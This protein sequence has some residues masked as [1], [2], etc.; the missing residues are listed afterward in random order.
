MK[1]VIWRFIKQQKAFAP[2]KC[3][4]RQVFPP[5]GMT[6]SYVV[7]ENANVLRSHEVTCDKVLHLTGTTSVRGGSRVG[8]RGLQPGQILH[9]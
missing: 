9:I 4:C 8:L 2:P 3:L 1:L 7:G 6:S 5:L